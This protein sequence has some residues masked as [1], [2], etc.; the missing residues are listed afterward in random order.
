MSRNLQFQLNLTNYEKALPSE[1]QTQPKSWELQCPD[2]VGC[3]PGLNPKLSFH[4]KLPAGIFF[5]LPDP[6]DKP[7]VL[8]FLWG[9][10]QVSFPC[11]SSVK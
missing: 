11:C 5:F 8:L 7:Q 10:L 1:T 3:I 9:K 2:S 4:F 6:H